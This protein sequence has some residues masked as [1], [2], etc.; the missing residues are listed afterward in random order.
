MNYIHKET[1]IHKKA[2][3]KPNLWFLFFKHFS[4]KKLFFTFGV[5]LFFQEIFCSGN[6]LRQHFLSPWTS[7]VPNK[8]NQLGNNQWQITWAE[9][10]TGQPQLVM[11]FSNKTVHYFWMASLKHNY[12]RGIALSHRSWRHQKT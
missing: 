10:G 7:N 1:W 9:L 6:V 3:S 8:I 4:Y 12:L 2:L 11:D 5:N